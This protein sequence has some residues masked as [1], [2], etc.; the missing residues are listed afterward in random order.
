MN[1]KYSNILLY[2]LSAFLVFEGLDAFSI[3]N[4]PIYWIGVSFLSVV[5]LICY[6]L[7]LRTFNLNLFSI[8]NWIIYGIFITLIQSFFND[9][10]LPKYASTSYFQYISLR[11]LRLTLFL[12]VIY[13]INYILQKYDFEKI[14]KFFLISS[15]VISTLSIVSYFSYIY[16]YSD[17]PRTRPGSGGWTQPIQRA[18][19]I[20][21]NYGTFREPSFLAIW[22]VPFIPYFFYLGKKNKVWY[23][24]SLIPIFSVVLSRSLTGIIA[25]VAAIIIVTVLL[26]LLHKKFEL[27]IIS[28]LSIFLLVIFTSGIFSYQFPPDENTCNS[29][30]LECVCTPEDRLDE[31]KNSSSFSEGTFGRFREI[32]SQGLDAFGN[33]AFLLEYIQN[34]GFS[35]FGEGYGYSNIAFSY[36]ADEAGKQLVENQIIYRNPGQVVSFNNLYANILMSTGLLGLL[37]FLYILIEILRKIVFKPTPLQPYLLISFITTLFVYSYQA[38]ELATHLAIAISFGLNLKNY[39][40]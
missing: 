18:C 4:I 25:F 27:N 20:L 9:L 10:I 5:Y 37:W 14:L 22:T 39:E 2:S 21:R 7:G 6:F 11:L 35:L 32:S 23:A 24:L 40:K 12:I 38:E 33:T 17:F 28:M 19:N 8:R 1:L 30:S 36:A 3:Q 34:T 13:A 26:Y 31:L 16:G 29:N 15:I